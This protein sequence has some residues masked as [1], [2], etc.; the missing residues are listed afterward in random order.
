MIPRIH[1]QGS[2]TLGLLAYLY[3]PGTHEEHV[4]PHLVASF[5]GMAPDPGRDASATESDL[6]QLLDQPLHLLAADQR[7]EQH[8]WHCSVRAAPDDPVLADEQWADIAR[9]IVAATGIDP[10][11]GAGCRWAAVRHADD[12]IHIIA[13]LVREDGRRPDHHRS[14]KRAQ[15]EAR[16]IEADYDLHRVAPG[17]GT[18]AKRPTSAERHKAE[19]LGQKAASRELLREHVHRALAGAADETEFFDRLTAEDVLVKKRVAPSGDVLGYAVALDGDHNETGEPVWYSGSKLAPDLSLPRI[20]K[21]FTAPADAEIPA[22]PTALDRSGASAPLRARYGAVQATDS[23]LTAMESGN[24][25]TAAAHLIGVGEV[26]GA[27]VQTTHG[28][29][30]SELQEAARHFERAA[31]SRIRAENEQMYALRRTARQIIHSGPAS[32]ADGAGTALLLDLM[33]LAAV[34]AAHWHTARGH[35]QQAEAAQRAALHLRA[36]YQATAAAPLAAL[37]AQGER[38]PSANRQR[39]TITIRTVLPHLAD[40]LQTEPGWGRLA[41]VLDQAERAGH[42]TTALLA[43]AAGQRELDSAASVGDTLVWRLHHL[44]YI[45]V[46]S[47]RVKPKWAPVHPVLLRNEAAPPRRR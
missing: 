6:Q 39:H 35:A 25:R 3:G 16:C 31:Q 29:A 20:R 15:A 4:D 34:A 45:T 43:K 5:D 30:R 12:H 28:A 14:G 37:R 11:D 40:R 2:K 38:L 27:L 1:K 13:T 44:G 19:R 47:R 23:A 46:P 18:A 36:A 7:P 9:R 8:V 42:D 10:G 41:A 24:D 22:Q 32:S 26:I 21:R 33:M 17:D